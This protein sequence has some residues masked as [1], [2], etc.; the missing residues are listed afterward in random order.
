MQNG[1]I[2]V[3]K[4]L[5]VYNDIRIEIILFIRNFILFF[6]AYFHSS[7]SSSIE[8]DQLFPKGIIPFNHITF[9]NFLSPEL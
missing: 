2:Y 4:N 3:F 6:G 7:F 5:I 9:G 8:I 1:Y